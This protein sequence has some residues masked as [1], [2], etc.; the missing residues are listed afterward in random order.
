MQ[1]QRD[2]QDTQRESGGLKQAMDSIMVWTDGMTE[3]E[4][5]QSLVAI[6]GSKRPTEMNPMAEQPVQH[7]PHL[8]QR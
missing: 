6:V 7:K 2:R 5:L 8:T 3:D 1:N 4:V